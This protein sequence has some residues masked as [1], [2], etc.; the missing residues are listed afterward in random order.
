ME[1]KLQRRRPPQQQN[2]PAQLPGQPG[3]ARMQ[4]ASKSQDTPQDDIDQ[5]S[6]PDAR[7]AE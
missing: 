5:G 3:R 2:R 7:N 6:E 1:G 4:A